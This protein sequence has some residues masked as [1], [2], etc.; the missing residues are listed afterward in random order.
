MK[1]F[2]IALFRHWGETEQFHTV[3]IFEKQWI[4]TENL[5]CKSIFNS[6]VITTPQKQNKTALVV[7]HYLERFLII[8]GCETKNCEIRITGKGKKLDL[9]FVFPVQVSDRCVVALVPKQTSSYNIPP[10]TS[11]SRTSISRYG[12]YIWW[13]YLFSQLEVWRLFIVLQYKGFWGKYTAEDW[14]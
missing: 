7:L 8:R 12:E 6:E 13:R 3:H 10:T 1:H 9:N 11:I 2:S 5:F 4:C 14:L